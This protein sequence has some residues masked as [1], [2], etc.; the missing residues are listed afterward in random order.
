MEKRSFLFIVRI[1]KLTSE[2]ACYTRP[3]K[4]QRAARLIVTPLDSFHLYNSL[5]LH[6][7]YQRNM[8]TAACRFTG[9]KMLLISRSLYPAAW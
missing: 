6:S 1:T 5:L 3:L 7:A 4:H 9:S 8:R 2:T